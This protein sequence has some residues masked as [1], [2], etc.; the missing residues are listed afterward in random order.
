MPIGTVTKRFNNEKNIK[1]TF[2]NDKDKSYSTNKRELYPLLQ[3]GNTVDYKIQ[4]NGQYWNIVEA[5]PVGA[6]SGITDELISRWW[7]TSDRLYGVQVYHSGNIE[8]D[9]SDDAKGAIFA[10][11]ALVMVM[12]NDAESTEE[13]D[14]SLRA[15]EYGIFQEW[16]TGER[17]DVHG[18]E[19]YSDAAATI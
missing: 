2:D 4:Q 17:A 15:V 16:A 3:E 9:G 11:E 14:N 10:K 5:T 6:S 8:A 18:V 19:I 13:D 7:K 12:A 1:V